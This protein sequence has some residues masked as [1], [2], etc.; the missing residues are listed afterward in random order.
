M[1]K[2][3]DEILNEY[4][5]KFD[6]TFPIFA[7]THLSDSELIQLVKDCLKSGKPYNPEWNENWD[8]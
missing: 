2:I 8:Y 4:S 3:L 5:D 6:D 7:V 1:E